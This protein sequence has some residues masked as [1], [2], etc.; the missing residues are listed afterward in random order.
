MKFRSNFTTIKRLLSAI[1]PVKKDW[2]IN[3]GMQIFDYM[4]GIIEPLLAA[5]IIS[6]VVAHDER[7]MIQWALSL[8]A[9]K[10]IQQLYALISTA[11]SFRIMSGLN[12]SL[13]SQFFWKYLFFDNNKTE[14]IGTWKMNSIMSRWVDSWVNIV[15]NIIPSLISDVVTIIVGFIIIFTTV[16]VSYA[17][18]LFILF[19]VSVVLMTFAQK[20]AQDSRTE[21]GA[22]INEIHKKYTQIIMSKFEIFQN[23]KLYHELNIIGVFIQRLT[24]LTVKANVI[25][26]LFN[27]AA[28]TMMMI[29]QTG[30]YVVIG[31]GVM[32]G[33]Y[34]IWTLVL[35]SGLTMTIYKYFWSV[36]RTM[37]NYNYSMISVQPFW[38]I[39]DNTPLVQ[40]NQNLPVFQFKSWDIELKNLNFAYESSK[41]IFSDFSLSLTGGKKY[42][43]VGPSG[44]G[45]TTLIKLIA[46]YI[47]ANSGV[48]SVD[49][50]KLSDISLQ[51][52]YHHI[53]YLTQEPNVFDGKIL[54]NL[55]YALS[56]E[57]LSSSWLQSRIEETI[58]LAKCEFIYEFEHGLETEVGERGVK[59]SGW[60]KQRLAIAKIMLKNP[61]IILLDEPTS[62]LDSINEESITEALHNLFQGRTVIVVAHRLQTVKQ[63][64]T[65]FYIED[66]K[67][68]EQGSHDTLV[69]QSGKYKKMLDLQSGF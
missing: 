57:E 25:I 42:A 49:D 33:E 53:G 41:E 66:G 46:G 19:S 7:W 45:K 55:T 3:F 52:Y 26:E 43:F 23:N 67:I 65:I 15:K 28:A 31:Y 64:D 9:V 36:Q 58:R 63:A 62:A 59:L 2:F 1:K 20:K 68:L 38:D 32:N 34:Q 39:M 10:F 60:Q 21:W 56:E 18:L 12:Y 50:Q 5:W 37:N 29:V 8:L 35:L 47:H 44:G 22:L 24:Q 16:P 30:I 13:S 48:T 54:E 51:S 61:E 69:L 4:Q 11:A 40:E 27:G 14:S 6:S 17:V